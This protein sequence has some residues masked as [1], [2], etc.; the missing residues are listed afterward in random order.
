MK[1]LLLALGPVSVL[2]LACVV[3]PPKGP[4]GGAPDSGGGGGGDGSVSDGGLVSACPASAPSAGGSCGDV[5]LECEYGHD[6]NI[7]CDLVAR[8]DA[9]GWTL[10][11]PSSTGCPTPPPGA[12]CPSSYA[13]VPQQSTCTTA[14]SCAYPEGTCACEVYCGAQYP[15]GHACEAGTPMTW[16]C[17]GAAGGCPASRPLVGSACPVVG[18]V[19]DYG[20]CNTLGVVCQSGTWHVQLSSCPISTRR[21]KQGVRYLDDADLHALADQTRSM[22][23]AT[24]A[25]TIG[26]PDPRLGFV[27]E[28]QPGS[29]AVV[30]GKDRVDLYAYTS[31]AVATLQVQARE[32]AELRQQVEALRARCAGAPWPLPR[33]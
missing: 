17:T 31:M 25:Y 14:T 15:V 10:T 3:A 28:D 2:L 9:T 5:G 32:I 18:E 24:Y 11:Q 27:I 6:V 1:R 23:L 12:S 7:D 22:R 26:D 8:C 20:D 29:P 33:R 4:D 30:Q 21:D 13:A 19:C 16:Q